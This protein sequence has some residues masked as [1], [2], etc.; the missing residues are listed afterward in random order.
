MGSGK[1]DSDNADSDRLAFEWLDSGALIGLLDFALTDSDAQVEFIEIDSDALES[2][3]LL[4]APLE[5]KTKSKAES[6]LSEFGL[7]E[8]IFATFAFG[9][10]G[11]A[12]L[13]VGFIG[14]ILVCQILAR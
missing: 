7:L 5:S 4:F 6:N 2:D 10:W 8:S 13:R 1:L 9:F 12:V 3:N 11:F 14:R